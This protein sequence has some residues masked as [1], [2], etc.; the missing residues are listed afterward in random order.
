MMSLVKK[1][2]PASFKERL[3]GAGRERRLGAAVREF[4]RLGAGEAPAPELLARLER[5]WDEDGFRAAGGYFEEVARRAAETRGPVLEIGSGLT[6]LLLGLVAGRRGVGVWTLEHLAQ[7]H[8]AT[9]ERLARHGVEGVRLTL[10]PLVDRGEFAWYDAPLREMP[11][12]FRLVIA[13]GPPGDTKGG[14]Y[15]LLPVMRAHLA[16]DA[17]LLLDDA[18]RPDEQAA[19]RRWADEFGLT[20]EMRERDGKSWA[21]CTFK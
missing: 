1:V 7:F 12:D 21:V 10:A 19:L 17:V 20:H 13:D 18:H 11:R 15:G 9:G 8:R 6:T 3:K 4:G 5:G 16:P 14:R 2:L